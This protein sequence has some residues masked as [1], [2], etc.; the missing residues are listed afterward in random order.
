MTLAGKGSR[1]IVVDGAVFRW[2]GQ[3]Q[4][5]LLP[6]QWLGAA[7]VRGRAG[8]CVWRAAGR[9]AA[10][11]A[12]GQLARAARHARS[13]RDGGCG[14]PTRGSHRLATGSPGTNI[15]TVARQRFGVEDI[16]RT[17]PRHERMFR[18]GAR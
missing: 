15:H 18:R 16:A 2:G 8:W 9:G 13:S 17:H 1:R 14:N 10:A 4:A 11:R 7:D 3:A 6:S 5:D 12:S